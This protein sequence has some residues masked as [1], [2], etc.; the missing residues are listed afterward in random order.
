MKRSSLLALAVLLLAGCMSRQSA[1]TSQNQQAR[2][3]A[4]NQK[5]E[6]RSFTRFLF[7]YDGR[8]FVL[9]RREVFPNPQPNVMNNSPSVSISD[10]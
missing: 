3:A 7:E 2:T 5:F 1:S 4:E 10:E 6:A 9:R 8:R